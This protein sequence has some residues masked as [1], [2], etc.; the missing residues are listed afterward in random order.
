M[1][2][3][4]TVVIVDVATDLHE[5]HA[6]MSRRSSYHQV[7]LDNP[8]S[9][10]TPHMC[11]G[12]RKQELPSEVEYARSRADESQSQADAST[13]SNTSIEDGY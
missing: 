3:T 6:E 13:V 8:G 2:Y 1:Q 12:Y 10:E 4:I 11:L 7:K 5:V 9:N